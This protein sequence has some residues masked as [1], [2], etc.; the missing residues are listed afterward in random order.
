MVYLVQVASHHVMSGLDV[1]SLI[2]TRTPDDR[3]SWNSPPYQRQPCHGRCHG[4]SVPRGPCLLLYSTITNCVIVSCTFLFLLLLWSYL[5]RSALTFFIILLHT[6]KIVVVSQSYY[7][8]SF[9]L[10]LP[11]LCPTSHHLADDLITSSV[12][13]I[14][15]SH[16]I[17]YTLTT[18]KRK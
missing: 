5:L 3:H 10:V 11:A 4:R 8:V 2:R 17:T 6:S 14:C 9:T 1:N 12:L 15:I 16:Y 18:Q 7:F 13:E